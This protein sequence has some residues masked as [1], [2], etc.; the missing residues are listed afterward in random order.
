M[1]IPLRSLSILVLL[2]T[3]SHILYAESLMGIYKQASGSDPVIA[4]AE[5]SY[6]AALEARPQAKAALRPQIRAN[7]GV[8]YAVTDPDP[9]PPLLDKD[10][11]TSSYGIS[12]DQVL[13]NKQSR[14]RLQQADTSIAQAEVTLEAARQELILR[15]A[16]AYFNILSAEDSLEFAS[17]EKQSI[18]RQL[19]QN[20]QRFEVGLIAITDVHETR[21]RYDI[22]S[23]QEIAAKNQLDIS[24]EV[25]ITLT[26]ATP[27]SLNS[28]KENTPLVKPEPDDINAWVK[29]SGESNPE[30]IAAEYSVK[31]SQ[32]Q[33]SIQKAARHPTV[34]L[35]ATHGYNNSNGGLRDGSRN[36]TSLGLQFSVPL[37]TSGL[38]RSRSR[39]AQHQTTV[40]EKQLESV[41]RNTTRLTRA[42]YLNVIS[43][44][45]QVKALKQALQSTEIAAE[46]AE[47]G[48]E[49]GTR[50]AVDV[51]IALTQTY[52]AQR[53]YSRARYDYIMSTL[54][55]KRAA[56]SLSQQD[57][58][59]IDQWLTASKN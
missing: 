1:K 34:G 30:L 5:A 43:Q 41:I 17:A 10:F 9:E 54:R 32:Q 35:N 25:L 18:K 33:T 23:A 24:K 45:S 3:G 8:G 12:L 27:Q 48:F 44:I 42:S 7:A 20:Q 57:I 26:G 49:V 21:A 39:E 4:S 31:L 38:I 6:L 51:L 15:V 58:T 52:R 13:Y 53:D 11:T 55:L 16:E 37:Y 28:L 56:G 40:A 29:T 14:I 19:D 47:A 46:A 22:S 2:F 59:D 36:D 50:T